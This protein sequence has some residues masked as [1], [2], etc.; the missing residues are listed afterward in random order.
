MVARSSRL[1][2]SAGLVLA[3]FLFG[4]ALILV[5]VYVYYRSVAG[6][7]SAQRLLH[8]L[9]LPSETVRLEELEGDSVARVSVRDLLVRGQDGDTILYAPTAR[10]RLDL[11]T[12]S[13]KRPVTLS[14]VELTDPYLNVVQRPNGDVN[15]GGVLVVTAGGQ[16]VLPEDV[17]AGFLLRDVR[18]RGGRVR[19][20]T[21][22]VPDSLPIREERRAQVRLAREGGVT[23][24]IRGARDLDARLPV[25]RFGGNAAWRAEVGA[26]SARL[27]DPDLRLLAMRGSVEA[28]SAAGTAARFRVDELRTERSSLAASGT[29]ELGGPT[30]G[31]QAEVLAQ[32]ADFA[33]LR[34]FVPALPAE[35]RV[36][37]VFAAATRSAER[38]EVAG[39]DVV[40]TAL[41]SRLAG[42]FSALV[43]GDAPASFR[44]TR[45]SLE[46]LRLETL[47]SLGF[48]PRIPYDGEIRGVVASVGE[49]TATAGSLVADLTA[50]F[51]PRDSSVAAS[52]VLA[53]GPVELGGA[54]GF[55]L[56]GVRIA[57]EPLYLA[58]LRPFAPP[59]QAAR[60]AVTLRGSVL[61]SGTMNEIQLENGDL[62]YEVGGAT[63]SR[64]TGLALRLERGEPLSFD[65]RARAEPLAL[66]TV[67]ELF[68]AIP[69]EAA[70]LSGPIHI[71]GT[72]DEVRVDVE[73]SG[74]PGSFAVTGRVGLGS[75]LTF[76]VSGRLSA[77]H[78]D[79]LLSSSIP[80]QGSL[81]G[82][83]NAAGS[84]ADLSFGV[85][86]TQ[87]DGR[88][89]LGGRVHTPTGQSP[90]FAVQGDL[91]D[92]N[93][94]AL[95][96]R[97]QLFPSPMTG[98][99]ELNGGGVQPYRLAAD[100]RGEPGA[101]EVRGGYAP[102]DIPTYYLSGTVAGL[103]LQQFPYTPSLPPTDLTGTIA[104][105]GRGTS[106]E[107][108]SGTLQLNATGSTVGGVPMDA[109]QANVAIAEGVLTVDTLEARLSGSRLRAEGTLGLTRPVAT[110]LNYHLVAPDLAVFSDLF[111]LQQGTP[112]RIAGSLTLDG[113]VSGS[114]RAPLVG[115]DF[116]GQGLRY[117]LWQA[118]RLE[119]QTDADLTNGLPGLRGKLALTG[120]QLVLP[121][122]HTLDALRLNLDGGAGGQVAV[123][124]AATRAEGSSILLAGLVQ[125]EGRTPRGILMDSLVVRTSVATWQLAR[126]AEIR[127]GGVDG[128]LINNFL[129]QRV[130]DEPGS[131]FVNGVLP[132][133]GS[134]ALQVALRNVDL[135]LVRDLMPNTPEVSGIVNLDATME[136]PVGDPEF[137]LDGRVL[138]FAYSGVALDS[139]VLNARYTEQK[140]QANGAIWRGALR[141]ATLE[142]SIPMHLGLE[143]TLPSFELLRDVPLTARI[144]TDSLPLGLLAAVNPQ[145]QDVT[146]TLTAEMTATGTVNQPVLL[147]GRTWRTA[148]SPSRSSACATAGSPGG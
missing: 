2:R 99:I 135:G 11:T 26:L 39:T 89:R 70:R 101:I 22:W 31:F 129:F 131:I 51:A 122:G 146:G 65:L 98:Q 9:N 147:G 83:F 142:G 33:D 5:G 36:T 90:I 97:A 82:T 144:V 27:T 68:P 118:G 71:F 49:G 85:D 59:E 111:P 21:P 108:L 37:G 93:L 130:D 114:L 29:L 86:L 74:S 124:G 35:G 43:G 81:T 24:R 48:G 53:Q 106:L 110:P 77:F 117:G 55:R 115:A 123:Q 121:G 138:G 52:T 120:E 41:G 102:G 137:T 94:G 60:L 75:P 57:L 63:P 73:L 42:H 46:P 79:A 40:V 139:V 136:G 61:A 14:Q 143:N 128:V 20:A 132:P 95:V 72:R 1:G 6:V 67:K 13:G 8:S 105:Q 66:A 54:A 100:L 34:W 23:M 44:D 141:V 16:E 47:D 119:F 126:Q 112:M 140:M 125:L 84:T 62:T 148:R 30:L 116:R 64:L 3:G 19:L 12:I 88:F 69:F 17:S 7:Q 103:N 76:D 104:L 133:T 92:F 145:L 113:T 96:G 91:T 134:L 15:L 4:L 58:A 80:V 127:W 28:T 56:A 25:V 50:T 109:L 87:Q 38:M 18:I 107:T 45:L 78:P 32:P 10:V